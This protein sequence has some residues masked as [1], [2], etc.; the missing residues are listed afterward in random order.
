MD[1]QLSAIFGGADNP[2]LIA[3]GEWNPS[4]QDSTDYR[5]VIADGI[6]GITNKLI[7]EAVGEKYASGQLYSTAYRNRQGSLMPLLMI[8]GIVYLLVKS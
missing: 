8:G 2:S 3:P 7:G 5:A 4:A 1:Q 6:R